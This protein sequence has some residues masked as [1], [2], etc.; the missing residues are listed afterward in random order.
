MSSLVVKTAIRGY[1][2]SVVW[3]PRV[4]ESLD[5]VERTAPRFTGLYV[6]G[7]AVAAGATS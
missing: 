3:E 6:I 2:D 1:H 4:G 5:H 7:R